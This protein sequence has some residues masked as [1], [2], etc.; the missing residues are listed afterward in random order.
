LVENTPLA[1]FSGSVIDVVGRDAATILHNLTT[2]HVKK[3]ELGQCVESFITEVKGRTIGHVIVKRLS[4][5]FRLIG[6]PGQ[7][8]AIAAQV[9]RYTI[10]EDATSQI[11]DDEF[12]IEVYPP[13]SRLTDTETILVPWL[14][15][16]S[17]IRLLETS[18][19]PEIDLSG[20]H[21][22]R[23]LAK[24]PWHGID[25]DESNLPQEVDR[26]DYAISFNKGCYLG[27]ETIAR[28]DAMGQVQKKL[29]RLL[30][31]GDPV[32]AGEVI[33]VDSKP[34]ARITSVTSDGRVAL[35]MVRRAWFEKSTNC[36][37]TT[38]KGHEFRAVVG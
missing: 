20:F 10:R 1:A 12:C 15:E 26:D 2:A 19:P 9:D 23:I 38:S 27:Q 35:A 14:G 34:V 22:A 25:F 4:D 8:A 17:S 30:I 5:R 28:L 21:D 32:P 16:G 37:G 24:F 6:S 31:Q 13:Q 18:P 11:R 7:S 3:L 33:S 36:L 29:V